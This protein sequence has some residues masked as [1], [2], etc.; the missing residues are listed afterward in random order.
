[1]ADSAQPIVA[2]TGPSPVQTIQIGGATS[3]T[4]PQAGRADRTYAA[5]YDPGPQQMRAVPETRSAMMQ[6]KLAG[7]FK[8]T[9]AQ[10]QT[11]WENFQIT[12][13]MKNVNKEKCGLTT[14][15]YLTKDFIEKTAGTYSNDVKRFP[16]HFALD[17]VDHRIARAVQMQQDGQDLHNQLHNNAE[18]NILALIPPDEKVVD[19][20]HTMGFEKF[21]GSGE[22]VLGEGLVVLTD[23]NIY[24]HHY[25]HSFHAAGTEHG[26]GST[27]CPRVCCCGTRGCCACVGWCK[28]MWG[29]YQAVATRETKCALMVVN[30]EDQ[31]MDVHSEH[32][33]STKLERKFTFYPPVVMGGCLSMCSSCCRNCTLGCFRLCEP[34]ILNGFVHFHYD[35][36][37]NQKGALEKALI[38][39]HKTGDTSFWTPIETESLLSG[40]MRNGGIEAMT[41][42]KWYEMIMEG[43]KGRTIAQCQN[44]HK[45]LTQGWTE[46]E[47]CRIASYKAVYIP[48]KDAGTR[49]IR[50][51]VCIIDSEQHS[52][53]EVF[54]FVVQ[55]NKLKMHASH[56]S[57]RLLQEQVNSM[58]SYGYPSRPLRDKV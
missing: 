7:S 57:G 39:E 19:K 30:I 3:N 35:T 58:D 42:E 33:A 28:E 12:N 14:D 40:V 27:S 16:V 49:R 18:V 46:N 6:A 56:L 41:D 55:A 47:T 31:L 32:I 54:N 52:T 17:S 21:P 43:L 8:H 53:Q 51:A 2:E 10:N 1:M 29:S 11:K 4:E 26:F 25:G 24:F 38:R 44:K 22:S 36:E 34:C 9:A 23:K 48:F 5:N 15:G 45:E 20:L 50:E 37:R 13:T